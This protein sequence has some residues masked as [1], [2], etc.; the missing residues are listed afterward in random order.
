MFIVP[1]LLV[2]GTYQYSVPE[3]REKDNN[4]EFD[5][6]IVRRLVKKIQRLLDNLFESTG[7]LLPTY[8]CARTVQVSGV[9]RLVSDA[10]VAE[11]PKKKKEKKKQQLFRYIIDKDSCTWYQLPTDYDNK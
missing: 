2:W 4:I 10:T 3:Q 5:K 6:Y 9:T 11:T 1:F 8:Y 7:S